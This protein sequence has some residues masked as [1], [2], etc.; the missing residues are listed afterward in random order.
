MRFVKF[1]SLAK[2]VDRAHVAGLVSAARQCQASRWLAGLACER[3]DI[4]LTQCSK[5]PNAA[6][7]MMEWQAPFTVLCPDGTMS[8]EAKP[9]NGGGGGGNGGDKFGIKR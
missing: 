9:D 5:T 6:N 2:T 4:A 7:S 8:C 3:S 1:D